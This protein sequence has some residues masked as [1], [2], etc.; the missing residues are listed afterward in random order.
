MLAHRNQVLH[1][2]RQAYA[3]LA[4]LLVYLARSRHEVILPV[5]WPLAGHQVLGQGPQ[6][7]H[8][9]GQRQGVSHAVR[10]LRALAAR[11]CLCLLRH[12]PGRPAHFPILAKLPAIGPEGQQR[13]VPHRPVVEQVVIDD[14]PHPVI[15]RVPRLAHRRP[16][17]RVRRVR[18]QPRQLPPCQVREYSQLLPGHDVFHDGPHQLLH[19]RE[20]RL[21]HSFDKAGCR[22]FMEGPGHPSRVLCLVESILRDASPASFQPA[23][24]RLKVCRVCPRLQH[25]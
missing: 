6:R 19:H 13:Q 15:H 25:L 7:P 24:N 21:R 20:R 9:R 16:H 18:S 14:L 12:V 2:A 8:Q 4:A 17:V 11:Q 5:L 10:Q 3:N 22:S 23:S 1:V